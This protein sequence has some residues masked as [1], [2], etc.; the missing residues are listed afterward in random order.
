M[1]L[2]TG[3]LLYKTH[4]TFHDR[5]DFM[6]SKILSGYLHAAYAGCLFFSSMSPYDVTWPIHNQLIKNKWWDFC[7]WH[8]SYK[9]WFFYYIVHWLDSFLS[10]WALGDQSIREKI[11]LPFWQWSRLLLLMASPIWRQ[12][13][14]HNH[15]AD[16]L[17]VLLRSIPTHDD[18]I[19]W[20]HFP[21]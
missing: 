17:P 6:L 13:T 3:H 1:K 9:L 12:N 21:R 20:K 4:C 14:C 18:V 19:K 10:V 16:V 2:K 11:K 5:Y 8:R 15:D 7:G